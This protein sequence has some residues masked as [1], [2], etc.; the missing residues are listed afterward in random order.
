MEIRKHAPIQTFICRNGVALL[1]TGS[2]FAL[3]YIIV[4]NF[5]SGDS[6]Y[7]D[8]LIWAIGMSSEDVLSSFYD[9]S[10][11]L[12]H[13]CVNFLFPSLVHNIWAAAAL[14]T[15]AAEA[16]TYFLVYKALETT[17][18]ETFP[19]WLLALLTLS[20]FLVN[21]L[22]LP[23]QYFYLGRGNINPW[24]N[25]TF[26]MSRPFAA[27]AFFMTVRIYNRRRYGCHK[28]FVTPEEDGHPIPFVGNFWT[29]F[30]T[31]VYTKAELV[32]Y[33]LCLLLCTYA[34]PAFL[35]FFAPAIFIF[36]LIDLIRSRG[37]LFPFCLKLALSYL[38]AGCVLLSQFF[39]FFDL[40]SLTAST[41]TTTAVNT[42]GYSMAI[43][44]VYSSIDGFGD[45]IGA[46]SYAVFGM[47][48]LCAFPLFVLLVDARRSFR[49]GACR[50][51][52]IGLLV[53]RLEAVLLHETGD[54]AIH[55]NFLWGYYMALWLLWCTAIGRFIHL[56]SKKDAVAK[57]AC[58]GGLLLLLWHLT[59]G[60]AYIIQI[61]NTGLY[62]I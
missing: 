7:I 40:S 19:R 3:M 28:V 12:W 23:G 4:F 13:I 35:Q 18:S 60:V 38:P 54:R 44:F 58:W 20:V 45:F 48:Y 17:V 53:G 52:L 42:S 24:H 57:T 8:H 37:K 26:L 30:R 61:L 29:Q 47:L 6:D 1:L 46:L 51:S 32:L 9:G 10:E 33:P 16:V 11:R 21:A 27:A 55:G 14:V 34:K 49:S 15:A 50:L 59:A 62:Q 5:R 41:V 39:G 31:P 22:T 56:W 25:P 2:L 43:Y 36:L